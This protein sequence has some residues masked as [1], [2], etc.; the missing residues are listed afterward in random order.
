MAHTSIELD[1]GVVAVLVARA[2]AKGLTLEAYLQSLI[3]AAP[4][5]PS[6]GMLSLAEFDRGLDELADSAPSLPVLPAD[7]SRAEIYGEHD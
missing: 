3:E 6:N 7:F 4:A 5:G 1:A 2:E